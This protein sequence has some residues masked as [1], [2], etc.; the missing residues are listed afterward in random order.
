MHIR[1][2]EER[3]AEQI[4]ILFN[5]LGYAVSR[6]DIADRIKIASG[7]QKDVL[8]IAEVYPGVAGVISLHLFSPF[9]VH[10]NW[11]TISSLVVHSSY[12]R[13]KIGDAL[14]SHAE[15]HA[16]SMGCTQIDL[17]SSESRVEAH[18]F[19]ESNG[20]TEQRK[21]YVKKVSCKM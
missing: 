11:A 6:V 14:I 18:L 13:Q 16:R 4:S 15:A 7:S 5:Q 17:S 2:A 1:M 10:S 21:R 3:D 12:R 9:H 8:M 19:Y 20:Y